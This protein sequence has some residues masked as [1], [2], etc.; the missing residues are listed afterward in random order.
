[1]EY[2]RY[3]NSNDSQDPQLIKIDDVWDMGSFFT[4]AQVHL[5]SKRHAWWLKWTYFVT[6]LGVVIC[7]PPPSCVEER[8]TFFRFLYPRSL[9]KDV[10]IFI[11]NIVLKEKDHAFLEDNKFSWLPPQKYFSL[12]IASLSPT[13]K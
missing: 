3:Y 13:L 1:M 4:S 9:K 7:H 8:T 11:Q 5:N 2:R 6:F 10:L 12:L